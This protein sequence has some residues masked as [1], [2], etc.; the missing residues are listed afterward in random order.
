MWIFTDSGLLMPADVPESADKKLT[1]NGKFDL[2]VRS[3]HEHHLAK[4]IAVYMDQG[5]YSDIQSTPTMDYEF[6]FYTTRSA[7]G[8]GMGRAIAAIDYTKFKPAAHVGGGEVYY[9]LLNRIWGFVFDSKGAEDG[10]G[11]DQSGL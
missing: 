6:R 8:V 4:F 2:Q 3:R 11:Y 10:T 9:G 7:F 5:S 1:K